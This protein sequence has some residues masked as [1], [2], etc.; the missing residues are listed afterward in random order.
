MANKIA[1]STSTEPKSTISCHIDVIDELY[2]RGWAID[3]ARVETAAI[4]HII[5]DG[6]E[7]AAIRCDGSR[8]DVR[9][10]GVA[11]E[12]VGFD[13]R[14]PAGVLDEESHRLEFRDDWRRVVDVVVNRQTMPSFDFTVVLRPQITSF[15]DGLR[16]GAFE[17]WA[18]RKVHSGADYE[19]NVMIKVT[20]D[21]ALIGHVRAN[22]HRGDVSRILSSPPNCGFRFVPP[23]SVRRGYSRDFRFFAMPEDVELSNSPQHSTIVNDTEEARILALVDSV[24]SLHRELTP[25]PP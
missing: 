23:A 21:G 14:L 16:Q 9:A 15:V 4:L 5:V 10:A 7:V 18:L 2:V 12:F 20:C 19:G 22:R 17:G 11:S 13:F 3:Q 1:Q 6:Q 8:P 24:D 25:D